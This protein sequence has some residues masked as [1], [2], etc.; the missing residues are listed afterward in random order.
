M[1]FISQ[2]RY[3]PATGEDQE[4]YRLKESFR[5]AA[6]RVR[7]RIIMTVGFLPG[8]SAEE[9]R[10][11]GRGLNYLQANRCPETLWGDAFS[12]Y[13]E[14]VR[15]HVKSI[16]TEMVRLD[17]VDV[18]KSKLD[19]GVRKARKMVYTDT[20][21]HTDARNVGAE[22]LCLQAVRQLRLEE[23]LLAQ[24]WSEEKVKIAVA[25]LITRTIYAQSEFRSIDIMWENSGICE[26][27]KLDE[28]KINVHS[29]YKVAPDFYAIKDKL[30]SYLCHQAD[31]LFHP[32]DRI[33]LFD[34]TNFYFEGRKD[35]SR[36]AK[37]GRSKEKRSDCKL[38]VLALCINTQG[39]VRYS[40]VLE[41][42]TADPK[43]LPDMIE[44]LIL[45]NPAN[46]REGDKTLVVIDAGIA[47]EENLALIKEKGYNYL[48]VSRSR[49]T[50]YE[51]EPGAKTVKVLDA[52]RKQ[53]IS[54]TEVR[55]EEGGDY[56]LEVQSPGKRLKEESMNRKF[57][58][59]FEE[60]LDAIHAS[61]QKKHGVKQYDK[62]IKR[63]GALEAKY[64]SIR[65]F[66]SI[67]TKQDA[68][69][70]VT[71]VEW[72][73]EVPD[74]MQFGTY[75][76]RTNRDRLDEKTTWDYYNLIRDIECTNR[77]LKTDLNLRPIYHKLDKNSDAHLFL[78]LLAYWIVN[79]IR[80]Q[81]G[82][83]G[84]KCYWTEIVRRMS[85]Q[86]A[87]TSIAYNPLGEEVEMRICSDP[88][89]H[90]AEIYD[91]L[92]FRRTPF[93]KIKICSTQT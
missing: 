75:F 6:G 79:T 32:T 52:T 64:P 88:T 60:G 31:S 13:S 89:V 28:D 11:I 72:A 44:K 40:S 42:N 48:C 77:Q 23:F 25:H 35:G 17:A 39:F 57:R 56:F 67:T 74:E 59:R 84:I 90:A 3:N 69:G 20:L 14:T 91:A 36:K 41:G 78:G 93:R 86:K 24:G 47:T 92:S 34:L 21:R 87:V 76:L 1:H 73:L 43:S 19:E 61:T 33:M 9:I 71:G 62:V 49:L 15:E 82:Q 53:E 7:S 68:Q 18:P 29:V 30:E 12:H 66:Y 10:D 22:W 51:L 80:F 4:Y 65:R 5:D 58:Q 38:L 26:L 54:L 46:D 45:E 8:L 50:D 2:I 37:F 70:N 16:W 81:L 63:I 27:L 85:T 55:H 83:R